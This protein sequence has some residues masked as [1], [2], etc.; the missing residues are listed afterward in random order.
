MELHLLNLS[1]QL[2]NRGHRMI[3]VAQPDRFV[4]ARAQ[5]L[6]LETLEG[7][8]VR[9]QD[10]SDFRRYRRFFRRNQV[11]VVH[12]HSSNDM[13]VAALTARLAGV[14]ARFLTW[15]LPKTFQSRAG[16]KAIV[17]LYTQLIAVSESVRQN[18]IAHGIAP[19]KIKT[20]HHGTDIIAFQKTTRSRSETRAEWGLTP[21][22]IAV[23]I[24]GRV[25]SEKGHR[26]LF[27]ALR[28]ALAVEPR[29]RV[30]VVGDG[31]QWEEM[32]TL[33][34]EWNLNEQIIFAGFREDVNNA[35]LGLDIVAVPSLWNEP[36][37][38]AVQQAMALSLPV[39]GTR[40]GGTPEMVLDGET[41]LLVPPADANALTAALIT[42]AGDPARRAS[43][44]K[45]GLERVQTHFTL[46]GMTDQIEALYRQHLRNAA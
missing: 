35:L 32:K 34:A 18:H 29:L 37:S 23:G 24:V 30:V 14:P 38:A 15:H 7:T 2:R 17:S 20:I 4:M 42:L 13:V 16:G 31:V 28:L 43:M 8:L 25:A 21:E 39:I 44:G 12:T 40:V 27:A 5:A 3:V 36:C 41:G 11:D 26:E 10:Y 22:H 9:Q 1:D 33:A 19:S 46:S 6:G 45:R